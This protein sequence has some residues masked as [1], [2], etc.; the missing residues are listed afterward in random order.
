ME[1]EKKKKIGCLGFFPQHKHKDTYRC[2]HLPKINPGQFQLDRRTL[3]GKLQLC[4]CGGGW[5]LVGVLKGADP[6]SSFSSFWMC[7]MAPPLPTLSPSL[8]G[9][10]VGGGGL[11]WIFPIFGKARRQIFLRIE[12]SKTWLPEDRDKLSTLFRRLSLSLSLSG[13]C[14]KN[15]RR[16]CKKLLS[17]LDKLGFYQQDLACIT[18]CNC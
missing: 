8:G 7:E 1:W 9:G 6:S 13:I 4:M 18:N 10:D 15:S 16:C 3:S 11:W 12:L 14:S 5:V 17:D 2:T